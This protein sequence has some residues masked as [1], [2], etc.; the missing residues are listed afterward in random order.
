MD[1]LK[2]RL[3]TIGHMPLHLNLQR[4]GEWRSEVFQLV[5]GIDNFSLRC[6]S[7][8]D[9]WTFSDRLLETQLPAH[10]GADLLVAVVNVPIEGNWYTRRLGDNQIVFTYSQIREYLIWENIPL[11]NIILRLLY[12]YTLVHR[13]AGNRIPS[14]DEISA[15][16]HDET[17]GCLFDMNGIK[18]DIVESCDKP[19]VC[20][21]CEERLNNERVSRQT[22]KTVQ[23]EIQRIRKPL[24]FRALDFVKLHPIVALVAS[25]AF[26]IVLGTVGSLIASFVYDSI[27]A[28]PSGGTTSQSNDPAKLVR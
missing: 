15:F 23:K 9:D 26:A 27:K 17:R 6:D 2:I 4:V 11:E 8:R 1:K 12:A 22:I 24:Y 16:T 21:D 18:T 3:V 25:S 7:D 5:G 19:V 10:N 13:R 20:S 28:K 14:I